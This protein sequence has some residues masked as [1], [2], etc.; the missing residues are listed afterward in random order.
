VPPL[1]AD[2]LGPCASCLNKNLDCVKLLPRRS[3]R[4]AARAAAPPQAAP[5]T[6]PPSQA[7]LPS[8]PASRA[9]SSD[10]GLEFLMAG[11]TLCAGVSDSA[12]IFYLCSES[13]RAKAA[14]QAATAHARLADKMY[15]GALEHALEQQLARRP[16]E[17][18]KLEEVYACS[19]NGTNNGKGK[20]RANTMEEDAMEEDEPVVSDEP[21]DEGDSGDEWPGIPRW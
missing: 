15:R 5:S 3:H 8:D 2:P 18:A 13:L 21:E 20:A 14:S 19:G 10:L 16:D 12:S 7:A 9:A 4:T 11:P 17:R 1:D 6:D